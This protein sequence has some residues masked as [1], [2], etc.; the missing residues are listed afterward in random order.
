[1][2]Y[3]PPPPGYGQPQQYGGQPPQDHPRATTA[4]VLGILGLVCCTPLAIPAFI[5]GRNAEREIKASPGRYAGEGKATA[6]KILGII[7]IVLLVIS[8][9]V[10]VLLLVTGNA[11][12]EFDAGTSSDF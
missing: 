7:G 4:M 12:F 6:G 9:L 3:Q 11:V 1:M 10:L 2:S 8:V 5:L